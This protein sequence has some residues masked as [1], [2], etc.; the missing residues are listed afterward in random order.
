ME[1]LI[2]P[3]III[4][5]VGSI[6]AFGYTALLGEKVAKILKIE[7]NSFIEWILMMIFVGAGFLIFD[8]IIMPGF[9]NIF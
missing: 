6:Y 3:G 9:F 5:I 2:I 4:L 7:K 1:I 8:L